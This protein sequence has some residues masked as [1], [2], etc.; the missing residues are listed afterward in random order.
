MLGSIVRVISRQPRLVPYYKV[1]SQSECGRAEGPTL[2]TSGKSD[3]ANAPQFY[4]G[5]GRSRLTVSINQAYC[6][7]YRQ[8]RF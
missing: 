7:L 2:S 3:T 1:A 5:L 4:P 6:R 8:H